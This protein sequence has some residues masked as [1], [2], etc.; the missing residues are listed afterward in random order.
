MRILLTA[1]FATFAFSAWASPMCTTEPESKWLAEDVMKA[2]A[3]ATGNT[4]EVFKKTKTGCYEIYGRNAKG[5]RIEVYYNPVSGE[6]VE[7]N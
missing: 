1:M 3:T 2:K 6:V 4:I 5:E 7:Q